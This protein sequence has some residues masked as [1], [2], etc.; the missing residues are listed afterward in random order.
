MS[1]ISGS[2]PQFE[3][4]RRELDIA[5][6]LLNR[7][8]DNISDHLYDS[9]PNDIKEV[10]QG[11]YVQTQKISIMSDELRRLSFP[12]TKSDNFKD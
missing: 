10:F 12:L 2:R 7:G 9:L 3:K 4:L 1:N 6:H 5:L 11:L 8:L